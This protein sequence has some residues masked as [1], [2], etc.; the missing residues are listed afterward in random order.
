[1]SQASAL[2]PGASA[3]LAVVPDDGSPLGNKRARE[4]LRWGETRY[5]EARNE[6]IDSGLIALGRGRGGSIRKI[7]EE[8]EVESVPV[9]VEATAHTADLVEAAG[10]ALQR[11]KDLYDPMLQVLKTEWANERRKQPVVV[12]ITANQGS[13][14]TGGTWSRPD[15]VSVE[16]RTY[17][18]VPGKFLEV[19]TFE[20]KPS[21]TIDV[22]AVYEALAHRRASSRSYVVLHVPDDKQNSL[23]LIIQEVRSVA[24][25]HGV[26]VVIA[27]E[28]DDYD[29][30]EE[31]E[32]AQRVEPDPEKLN[33]F[34]DKQLDAS[35][36][37]RIA[38]ALR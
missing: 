35:S 33:D 30:W 15:L 19:E 5:W 29:T 14:S 7:I 8:V 4:T 11:E 20:V 12:A 10:T 22:Q 38:L 28:P 18:Y 25:S 37:K 32:E 31:V 34:I 36:R 24:R 26:G 27:G 6:L 21:N 13:R 17:E 3:L 2:T 9:P 23:D 16:V 1:M